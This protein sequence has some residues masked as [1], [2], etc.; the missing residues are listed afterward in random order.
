MQRA[1]VREF[2]SR[3]PATGR[4]HFLAS[5]WLLAADDTQFE[6][7]PNLDVEVTL[8]SLISDQRRLAL[9]TLTLTVIEYSSA[10]QISST[11]RVYTMYED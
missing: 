1:E 2:T 6:A 7:S 3:L 9:A 4:Q 5:K 8:T 10:L 11:S